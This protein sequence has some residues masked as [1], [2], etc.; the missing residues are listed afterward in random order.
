MRKRLIASLLSAA[1]LITSVSVYPIATQAAVPEASLTQMWHDFEEVPAENKT[2]PLWFWNNKD[3]GG[4]TKEGIRE[5]MVNSKEKSGY[6]GFGILPNWINYFMTDEYLD[7]YG[8]ALETAK[9]LGMQMILYDENGYPSGQAGKLLD[10]TYP[11]AACKRLDK[12]EIDVTGPAEGVLALPTGDYR[13]YQ[14]AVAMN[15]DTKEIIDISDK[16]QLFD[17]SVPGLYSS[18]DYS[19]DYGVDKAFDTDRATR[20]NA[21]DGNPAN[22]WLQV[23]FEDV[24]TVDRMVVDEALLLNK[25]RTQ[26]YL[27]EYFKDG[28]W[29]EAA[30]GEGLGLNKEITFG[31]PVTSTRFRLTIQKTIDNQLPSINEME[32][33]HGKEKLKTPGI[34]EVREDQV[35]Y[36]VEEGNWKVMA[37]ATVKNYPTGGAD[38]YI[39]VDYLDKESVNKYMSLTFDKYYE[40][41]GEYFGNVI[42]MAFFDEPT[43]YRAQGRS[44]TSDYNRLFEEKYN[45]SPITMYPSMW[46]DI[47]EETASAR[48]LLYS[49]RSDLYAENYVKQMDD[50]CREHG[51]KLTGHQDQEEPVNPT[52]ISGDLM[53]VFKYQEIPGVDD[54]LNIDRGQPAYKVVSSSAN[55][56]DHPLVMTESFGAMGEGLGVENMYRDGMNIFS[57]GINLFIPHAIWYNNEAGVDNPPELSYRSQQ[58]GPALWD[59]NEYMGRLQTVLQKGRHVSDIALL[60]PIDSLNSEYVNDSGDPYVGGGAIEAD[61]YMGLGEYL[62]N[63]VQHDYT[64]LH[65]EVL[66]ENCTVNG[67][68]IHLNNEN[69]YEDYK[70]LILPEQKAISPK[71]LDRIKEYYDN[72]GKIIATGMLPTKAT[73]YGDNSRVVAALSEIF[74]ISEEEFAPKKKVSYSASTIFNDSYG[75]SKAFD[76]DASNNSRWNAG[77][78]SGG[79]Q[80]L[81]V[82]FGEEVEIGRTVIKENEPYRI[83]NYHIQYWDGSAWQNCAQGD[84][85]GAYKEDIFPAVRTTK[86]RLYIDTIV[87]D[88]VSIQEFET[89]GADGTNLA[90]GQ[91]I[92]HENTNENGGMAILLG[93]N[94]QEN[95]EEALDKCVDTYDVTVSNQEPAQLTGGNLTYIH[96]VID[97]QETYFFANSSNQNVSAEVNLRGEL[98][99]LYLWNPH[100][101]SREK[102]KTTIKDGVTTVKLNLDAVKSIFMVNEGSEIHNYE[103]KI[104]RDPTCTVKGSKSQHCT[105]CKETANPTEIPMKAHDYNTGVV[106]KQPTTKE[107]GI[108]T[109]TCKACYNT[110]LEVISKLPEQK[111]TPKPQPSIKMNKTKLTLYTKGQ[112]TA[113][114]K[115]V[116]KDIS[117]KITWI[118]SKKRVAVVNGSGKISVKGIGTTDITAKIGNLKTTCKV[119]VKKPSLKLAKT[120]A[121]IK[122]GKKLQLKVSAKPSTKVTYV[123]SNKKVA[124]VSKKGMITA[125]K[126]GNAV[127]TVKCNGIKK[128]FQVTVK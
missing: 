8:Y 3:I 104:D 1:L 125:K 123:T 59:F 2:R 70:V 87:S 82:D 115:A 69:N 13:T 37:F 88:S 24:K 81:E 20:W 108:R 126:K 11:E 83:T 22:Q 6:F 9:E 28:E 110:K 23:T 116:V 100:D 16:L 76:G 97:A 79:D 74:G 19:Q 66:A 103:W 48:E 72:G 98:K 92:Y 114:L 18:T 105:L 12:N 50:W 58:Y 128:N 63:K 25:Y 99:N 36:E 91:S 118:S 14:G 117:G 111:P 61:N 127:I 109:Y 42:D 39:C 107:T 15:M 93:E 95:L 27:I 96:K 7:L 17:D 94:Y 41:F 57:K 119:T 56:Y 30:K 62:F 124:V 44:W 73:E 49:F 51:I 45:I 53:K 4:V 21:K 90:R 122:P 68:T 31:K 34:A 64:Y 120:K 35:A 29:K 71:A 85:V 46:Y 67:D 55:N 65:P 32:L 38:N 102:A 47:G 121:V 5:M 86:M 89:Y 54:I 101:G 40:H 77:D 113:K 26:Q 84:S 112:T 33:Y 52:A 80:W 78:L 43:L 60:Y 106:T 75:A 10:Q